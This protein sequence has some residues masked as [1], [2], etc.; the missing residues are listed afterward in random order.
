MNVAT[1]IYNCL[2]SNWGETNPPKTDIA[3][4]YDEFDSKN[5]SLQ[6]LIENLPI[7][8]TWVSRGMYRVEHKVRITMYMKLTSYKDNRVDE[9]KD[10]WFNTKKEIDRIL[11]Q[12]KFNLTDIINLDL[13]GGWNDKESIAVGRGIKTVREP[14]I[15]RSEQDVTAVYYIVSNLGME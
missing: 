8:S 5:P 14:I 11:A 15:W 2:T 10:T 12:N 3:W 9:Y 1:L 4:K 7:R 6:V 13:P